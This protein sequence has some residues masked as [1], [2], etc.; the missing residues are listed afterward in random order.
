MSTS[1]HSGFLH[2]PNGPL[3]LSVFFPAP[4][5]PTRRWVLHVPAFAEEMNRCRPMVA[6]QARQL[7]AAGAV[8]VVP[9]LSG[10][11]DSD[12]EFAEADW[13][14]WLEDVRFLHRWCAR[15]GDAPV[16]LWGVRLGCL[17]ALAAASRL[18]ENSVSGLLMWQPVLAGAT[19]LNQFLRLRTAAGMMQGE[20]ES[21]S[22]LRAQL[23][24]GME[25]DV[26]GY[27]LS[28]QLFAEVSGASAAGQLP[29]PG[30][31]V[32]VFEVVAEAGKSPLPVTA[33]QVQAWRD[34][35]VDCSADT[36]SGSPFWMT[37]EIAFAPALLEAT[38]TFF[39]GLPAQRV[40]AF[41]PRASLDPARG[42]GVH[43]MV[44]D[45]DTEQLVGQ[46]HL[47][48]RTPG[49]SPEHTAGIGVLIVVGGPQYRVG[50]HRQFQQLAA[51]LA[52][53]GV[54]VLR[55]DYRG[56]GDSAG[57]LRGFTAVDEDIRCALDAFQAACPEVSRVV[58]WGLCDAASASVSYAHRDARVAALVLANPWV[59][60]AQGEAQA[61]LRHYYLG[62]L[63][64]R[65]FW[66]K[67]WR[68]EFDLRGSARSLWQT[69]RNAIGGAGSTDDSV[70]TTAVDEGSGPDSAREVTASAP[71]GGDIDLVAEFTA[72]IT[73]FGGEILLITSGNDLTAAEFS[74]A[75]QSNRA[76]R[77]RLDA[78]GV[79]RLELTDSDHTFSQREW[80]RQVERATIDFLRDFRHRQAVSQ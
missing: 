36:V 27:T 21:V 40:P 57:Q 76:L 37:Q 35:G 10:T 53:A 80:S 64:S 47:P 3:H 77:A 74:D 9:D 38:R 23:E 8:V 63:L 11:G 73:Q 33:K 49:A 17:L 24:S 56:M 65:A 72:G 6:R 39:E 2:G 31:K 55:F 59:Y 1:V 71:A 41:D 48:A 29:P 7:A 52:S 62:R 68:G 66:R 42:D 45:C 15:R 46:L 16:A 79:S 25:L 44:F 75:V 67:L 5:K 18:P 12:G 69:L 60:S 51:A 50:S 61:F 34:A 70:A 28:A 30:C 19:H 4:D 32:A 43:G 78:R 26:A 22:D 58:L 13:S 20:R 14:R 54:P